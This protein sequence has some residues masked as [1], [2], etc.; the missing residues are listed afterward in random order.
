MPDGYC[1][2]CGIKLVPRLT[3]C[4][5][6]G[7]RIPIPPEIMPGVANS[8]DIH[9]RRVVAFVCLVAV[10]L[11]LLVIVWIVFVAPVLAAR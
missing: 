6:C 8:L 11:G 5:G 9:Y 3:T 10:S 7:G 2:F 4:N 1:E